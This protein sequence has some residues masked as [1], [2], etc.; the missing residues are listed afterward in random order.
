MADYQQLAVDAPY[1]DLR[2][3]CPV[4]LLT[5]GS[6][7]F[8]NRKLSYGPSPWRGLSITV[9]FLLLVLAMTTFVD[10][11]QTLLEHHTIF[12][13]VN[14]TDAHIA[15]PGRSSFALPCCWVP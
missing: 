15:I 1:R 11:Y 8:E 6:R 4:S 10:R 7:L 5:S 13:G 12:D 9:G 14:Y 3:R 2:R